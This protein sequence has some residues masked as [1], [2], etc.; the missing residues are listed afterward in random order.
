M[1]NPSV[2]QTAVQCWKRLTT[3]TAG[4]VQATKTRMRSADDPGQ[5]H[6]VAGVGA[7][8][9]EVAGGMVVLCGAVVVGGVVLVMMEFGSGVEDLTV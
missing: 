8:G 5:M 9:S 4:I 6:F 3:R 1:G 2:S 7:G